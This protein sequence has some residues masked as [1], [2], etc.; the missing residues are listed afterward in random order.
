MLLLPAD[1]DDVDVDIDVNVMCD[2]DAGMQGSIKVGHSGR[3]V[4]VHLVRLGAS[5]STNVAVQHQ[6]ID[7]VLHVIR[8]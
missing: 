5:T 8:G 1:V 7:A 3:G 6:N 4:G 2:V